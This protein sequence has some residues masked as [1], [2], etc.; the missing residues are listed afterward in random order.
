[1]FFLLLPILENLWRSTCRA[2]IADAPGKI[3]RGY[4]QEEPINAPTVL[5]S[6]FNVA[7]F[8]DGR[9]PD[10]K[11][12]TGGPIANPGEMAASHTLA[13]EVLTSIPEYL[14]QFKQVLGKDQ[15][16]IDEVT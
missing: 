13:V 15:I 12:Q 9:A 5:N 6:S 2:Y 10:L 4:W 1:M 3:Y 7:Q 8:W 14:I 16:T 11:A